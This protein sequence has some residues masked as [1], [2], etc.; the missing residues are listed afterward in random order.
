MK[1]ILFLVSRRRLGMRSHY[2]RNTFIC[3]VKLS[4]FKEQRNRWL[5]INRS[6]VIPKLCNYLVYPSFQNGSTNRNKSLH[7]QQGNNPRSHTLT[8]TNHVYKKGVITRNVPHC[9]RSSHKSNSRIPHLPNLQRTAIEPNCLK[10][11]QSHVLP[12]NCVPSQC[13]KTTRL[14]DTCRVLM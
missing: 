4:T 7:S 5:N 6:F 12:P 1:L 13:S 10:F 14:N 2:L 3:T 9:F 11:W 8:R